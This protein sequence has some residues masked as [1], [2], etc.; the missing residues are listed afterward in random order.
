MTITRYTYHAPGCTATRMHLLRRTLVLWVILLS[1]VQALTAQTT[2]S[3]WNLQQT[4]QLKAD[5]VNFTTDNLNNIYIV[6]S[7]NQVKKLNDKLDSVGVFNDIRRYGNITTIDASNPLKVLV[8]Y[9][10]FASI[11]VLDRFLNTRN[12]IDL[13]S[14]NILQV[15]AIAQ[16]YDNNLWLFDELDNKIK[17]LDDNGK[18]LMESADFRVLF[19]EVPNPHQLIDNNGFLYLYNPIQGWLMFDYYG[20]LKSRYAITRWHDVQVNNNLLY[21][22]DS[23]NLYYANPAELKLQKVQANIPLNDALKTM[24]QGNR[25]Y[26]LRKNG[27]YVYTINKP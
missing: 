20:A 14:Q 1:T 17:K 16:S 12:T 22:R 4:A 25:L 24:K 9:K 19:E 8:Y 21:G 23:S 10:D 5:I 6:S 26:V 15:R 13:R 3:V 27:L 2:D 11:V 7:T 18:V